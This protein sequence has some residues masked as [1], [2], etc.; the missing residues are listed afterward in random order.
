MRS[1]P[2]PTRV[3]RATAFAEHVRAYAA[4]DLLKA[5]LVMGWTFAIIMQAFDMI[6]FGPINWSDWAV[7]GICSLG[8]VISAATPWKRV[9]LNWIV[10]MCYLSLIA[11]F[12]ATITGGPE[13]VVGFLFIPALIVAVFFWGMSLP[14]IATVVPCTAM[15]VVIAFV[16]GDAG[17][18]REVLLAAPLLPIVSLLLGALFNATRGASQEQERMRGTVAAL[19]A[20]LEARDGYTAEHS[21]EVLDLVS[22]VARRLRLGQRGLQVAAYVGLLHDIGKIGIPNS[23]LNKQGPLNDAEWKIMREHPV[24][25]EQ[26]V[27]EVPGFDEVADAVRHEHERWDGKGYPDGISKEAIP[28]ASR[29]VLA[30]DAYH[31]MTS[32]RPYRKSIGQGPAREELARCAGSQ[33]DPAVVNAL[34]AE[35]DDRQAHA[36]KQARKRARQVLADATA[37]LE[38]SL[39]VGEQ[40]R[41]GAAAEGRR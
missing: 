3:D 25:G 32:D 22:S 2:A 5:A 30:C 26:I 37:P 16:T 15:M 18:Q 34:L 27:R 39:Y 35:L 21:S 9:S 36:T 28:V 11:I 12:C 31:A 4:H 40:G 13:G 23:V 7:I 41:R 14:M 33:F 19:L 38:D 29:I 20:S 6:V 17:D 8:A 10:P 1:S 24:I